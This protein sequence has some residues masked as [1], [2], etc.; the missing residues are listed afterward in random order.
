MTSFCPLRPQ[1]HAQCGKNAHN[2]AATTSSA[3]TFFSSCLRSFRGIPPFLLCSIC[4]PE[5]AL[6]AAIQIVKHQSYDHPNEETNPIHDGQ[7]GHQQ[8]AGEDGDD[9]GDGAARSAEGA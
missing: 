9:G 1:A 4:C 6:P 2:A 5:G 8:Q 3:G 7:A